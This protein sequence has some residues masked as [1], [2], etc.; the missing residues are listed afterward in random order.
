MCHL[1]TLGSAGWERGPGARGATSAAPPARAA[2]AV[3]ASP[4]AQ[5]R[6]WFHA[7]ARCM[8]GSAWLWRWALE[9]VFPP[10]GLRRW[11]SLL[12]ST[13]R[14]LRHGQCF[15]QWMIQVCQ[16]SIALRPGVVITQREGGCGS[17]RLPSKAK[18]IFSWFH[19]GAHLDSKGFLPIET[20][21]S[22]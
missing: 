15:H 17:T 11:V 1:P 9:M 20:V 19:L 6:P 12:W 8:L 14:A 13:S 22:W 2:L 5:I 21:E 18:M 10:F 4:G 3:V 16:Q 7:F